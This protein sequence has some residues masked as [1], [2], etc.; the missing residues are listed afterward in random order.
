[1]HSRSDTKEEEVVVDQESVV[2]RHESVL[3]SSLVELMEGKQ[4]SVCAFE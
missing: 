1:M 4:D 2:M 3:V